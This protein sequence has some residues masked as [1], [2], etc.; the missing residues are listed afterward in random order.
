M[1]PGRCDIASWGGHR[2]KPVIR[3]GP[4]SRNEA[5]RHFNDAVDEVKNLG[6]ASA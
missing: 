4:V 2:P 6:L 3:A 1:P 5:L